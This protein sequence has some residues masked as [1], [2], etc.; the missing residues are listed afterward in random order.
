M[1]ALDT[2]ALSLVMARDADALAALS[3]VAPGEVVVSGPVAAEIHYGLERLGDTRRRRLLEAEYTRLLGLVRWADWTRA[4]AA[5]FG[6]QKA[7]LAAAGTL[8]DDMDLAI[9]AI[10]LVLGARLATLNAR[11][12][13]RIRGLT[14]VDWGSPPA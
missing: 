7:A 13:R 10:A 8:I 4:A 9:G 5:E 12:F 6:K 11:H 1:L 14:V 3:A 2:S